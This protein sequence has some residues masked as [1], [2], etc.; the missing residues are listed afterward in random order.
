MNLKQ[1]IQENKL[2]PYFIKGSFGIE[3]EG[4]RVDKEGYLALTDHPSLFGNRNHHP[5]IQTDFSESQLELVTPPQD[6]LEQQYQWL[7]AL[8][9]V[10]NRTLPEDEFV[11]PFSMPNV[12]PKE[13]DIPLIKVEDSSE[14]KYRENLAE[15]YGKKKQMISGVHFNFSFDPVLLEKLSEHLQEYSELDE[16]CNDLYL[17][18]SRNYLRY[19]WI[20]TYLFGASPVSHPSLL[21][22][23][24]IGMVRSIRNSTYGYHNTF[25]D[26]V[27]YE[28]I[29]RYIDDIERLVKNNTLYEERE[30]YGSSRLRGKGKYVCQLINNG[31]RYVE[32]RS[33]DVNPFDPLGF[34]YEQSLFV[35]IYLLTMVWMD[36]DN[37]DEDIK[38]GIEMNAQTSLEKPFETSRYHEEGLSL[39]IMMKK[40]CSELNL[41][42][43][44]AD[45]I[46]EAI[47]ILHHPEETLA[48]KIVTRLKE[49]SSFI[50]LG[51]EIGLDYKQNSL[52]KPFLL[53][54]F[55]TMEMS[56]Q[57]LL[58][59]ALQM[60]IKTT[61]LD[62]NDQFLAFNYNGKKEYV[63]NGNMTS[64]DTYISH[65]I[66]ANKTVTKKVL[67]ENDF[68]V[69]AGEEF[70]SF[71]EAKNH[72]ELAAKQSIVVKPKSTNYGIGISIFKQLPS[73]RAYEDALTIAFKEDDG[74]LVEEYIEGTEYRFFV[75]DEKVEAVLLREPANITGDGKHTIRELIA[76]KNKHPY[77]GENHRAPLEKIKT[78]EIEAL[79]LNEQDYTFD[80]II[81]NNKKVYLRENSNISTGG[82]SIDVTDDI[83]ESYKRIAE[84]IAKA[85]NVKVTG[86]DLIIPDIT[87]ASTKEN[88]GYTV[89]EANFNPAMNMH[90]FVQ[91]G[92]GRR[93]SKKVLEMLYP[94][95]E[96][97]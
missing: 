28:S 65:W 91:K 44:Y 17:K 12:L 26:N 42:D 84:E 58:Y 10:V 7:K 6:T 96:L 72:Y 83:H 92:K 9:D 16:W 77:R 29:G 67:R 4:L 62:A 14:I 34:S 33:F 35:H 55:E 54:G 52:E 59:D 39:L 95:I 20:L 81:E 5:Y 48:A 50:D 57:L 1:I 22:S 71:T 90:A 68:S 36:E 69:P 24:S 82:D 41:P 32:F 38:L 46:D 2:E 86:L 89:I 51:I 47:H 25:T 45:A 56:S 75:L 27:S 49:K 37:S 88:Q 40:T 15:K 18:M 3:K 94:D 19:Q 11:W 13:E 8:H 30:Y 85:L 70:S 76:L 97:S 53:N 64:K 43:E 79:M 80:S 78:G 63:R 93:L 21:D 31:A 66:M 61:V 74:I 60:G 87:L 73:K 23:E